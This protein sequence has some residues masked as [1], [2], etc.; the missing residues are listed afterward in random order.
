MKYCSAC[1]NNLDIS[2]FYTDKSKKRGLSTYCKSCHRSKVQKSSMTNSLSHRERMHD[3]KFLISRRYISMKQRAI[4]KN[5]EILSREEFFEIASN[6]KKLQSLHKNW[7]DSD[8]DTKLSPSVDRI[9]NLSGYVKE[10]IQF[11][12]HS[13]NV[14]KGNTETKLGKWRQTIGKPVILE[15]SGEYKFFDSGIQA[16]KWFDVHVTTI[17]KYIKNGERLRGWKIYRQ[18]L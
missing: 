6:S 13:E 12:T 17:Y 1:K 10:N 5:L 14:S 11:L 4:S 9:V 18:S 15:K 2:K 7:I 8:F 3:I 16:S